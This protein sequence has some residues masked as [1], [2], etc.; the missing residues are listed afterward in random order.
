M[1]VL[2]RGDRSRRRASHI[3][4]P[5]RPPRRLGQ[6]KLD[7]QKAVSPP[8]DRVAIHGH[9][10]ILGDMPAEDAPEPDAV[11]AFGVIAEHLTPS[12]GRA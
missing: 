4:A 6:K 12:G 2:S 11:R 5:V 3:R 9:R 1:L 8:L 10:P 7:H